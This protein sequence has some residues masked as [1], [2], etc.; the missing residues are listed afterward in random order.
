MRDPIEIAL[1]KREREQ[2]RWLQSLPVCSLCGEH[3]QDE[4]Y[5]NLPTIGNVC[6]EC[7]RNN[8]VYQ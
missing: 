5:C 2:E 6:N 7:L 8:T 3:I 1:N 4:T